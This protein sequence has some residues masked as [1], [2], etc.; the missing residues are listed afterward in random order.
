[1]SN[2]TWFKTQ[3]QNSLDLFVY[4]VEQIPEERLGVEAP[5]DAWPVHRQVYHLYTY[6]KIAL[7]IKKQWL[8]NAAPITAEDEVIMRHMW[9]EQGR[10]WYKKEMT[11]WLSELQT[12]RKETI[13]L[14]K[15]FPDEAWD[16]SKQTIWGEKNLRWVYTKTVQHTLEHT[17][18]VMQL[19]L[20]WDDKIKALGTNG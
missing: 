20:F 18:S 10:H 19:G 3:L 12:I 7:P 13:Q 5:L 6:E 8:A 17:N 15:R 14:V 1:M 2:P 16:E 4:A 9:A 11:H